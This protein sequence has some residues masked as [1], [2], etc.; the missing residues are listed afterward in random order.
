[1]Y[2][3]IYIYIYIYI[4]IRIAVGTYMY[5]YIYIYMSPA[6]LIDIYIY[7]S[8]HHSVSQDNGLPCGGQ[9][10]CSHRLVWLQYSFDI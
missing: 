1:M 2:V 9:L 10:L 6:I 8:L 3:C 7:P 4:S 5:A